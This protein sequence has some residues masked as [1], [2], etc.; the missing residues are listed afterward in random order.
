LRWRLRAAG[1]RTGVSQRA[2]VEHRFAGD[3]FAFALDQFLMDGS[4]LGRMV[5][6]HRWRGLPLLALPLAAAVRGVAI[7]LATAQP[8]WI[9]Y[10][11][12]FGWFNYVGLVRGLAR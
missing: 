10:Y 3:D 11:A 12:A 7:S 4:G 5:R 8:Q 1:L 9:P 6:K 2:L